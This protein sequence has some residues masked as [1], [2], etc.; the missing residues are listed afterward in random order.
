MLNSRHRLRID[1]A[2]ICSRIRST[3]ACR[4]WTGAD[5]RLFLAHPH[6]SVADRVRAPVVRT[7]A[8]GE[9]SG[10][11]HSAVDRLQADFERLELA[12]KLLPLAPDRV[13][14][15]RTTSYE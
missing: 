1:L 12:Q 2:G 8:R 11:A 5:V 13:A 4:C 9:Q 7:A 3:S 6:P 14:T 15:R 10:L